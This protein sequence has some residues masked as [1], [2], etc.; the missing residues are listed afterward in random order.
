M[1]ALSSVSKLLRRSSRS[2][3]RL[4]LAAIVA[5]AVLLPAS[6][7]QAQ[8]YS[9]VG[10]RQ[11][12][13]YPYAVQNPAIRADRPYAIEV[14]PGT[15]IIKRPGEAHAKPVRRRAAVKGEPARARRHSKVDP[16]LIEELRKRGKVKHTVVNTTKIVHD[17]PIVHETTRYVEDPPRV[18]ERYRV[19]ED[20]RPGHH[21]EQVVVEDRGGVLEKPAGKHAAKI[22]AKN[23]IEKNVKH[24][25]KAAG[26]HDGNEKRVIQAEA[27]ITILGPDRM[28]IRLFR[29]GD[30]GKANARAD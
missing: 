1:N 8:W 22:I 25:D 10:G 26:K 28:T 6:L 12:P 21:R 7:A 29:K 27:E 14:A 30:G 20:K 11:P 3:V 13:L 18:V 23:S 9:S 19:V 16:A 2:A 15:Y 4:R 24:A 17:K 5:V